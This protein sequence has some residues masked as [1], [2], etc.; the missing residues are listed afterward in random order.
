MKIV[1]SITLL[2]LSFSLL[3]QNLKLNKENIKVNFF[4]HGDQVNGTVEGFTAEININ[5]ADI[6]KSK[7]QGSVDVKT[8]S[9]GI[10]MRDKH[11]ISSDFFHADKHPKM[12][13]TSSRIEVVNDV[14]FV[15]GNLTIKGTT[16]E[17]R[18]ELKIK[19]KEVVFTS[20]INTA[21]YGVMKKNKREKTDVD[22]TI[23]IP[24]KA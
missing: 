19:D 22:I 4:F 3:A 2:L 24:K 8:I 9:T 1:L 5:P 16:K 15:I 21:D 7:V 23:T 10:P 6:T 20:R 13:F 14:V 11:L 17:E 12:T 18:F